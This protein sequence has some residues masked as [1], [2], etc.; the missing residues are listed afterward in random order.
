MQM[1]MQMEQVSSLRGLA[2]DMLALSTRQE[3]IA[4][5]IPPDL[6]DLRSLDLT[7][8]QHRVQKATVGVRDNLAELMDEA[9]NR[10]MKLLQKLDVL[11]E[12]MGRSLRGMEENRAQIAR[13]HARESLAAS[14]RLVI[15]L[16]T[17]AQMAGGSGGGSGSPMPSMAEQLKQLAKEQAGLNGATE[18]LRRMLA[19][20][21]MSQEMRSQMKRLGEEQAGLAG[22]MGELAE[23]ERQRQRPEGE[24]VLGDL[25]EL[26][27]N[28]ETIGQELDDGLVSEETLARQER[29]LSRM[30]DARN[31]VRR[32]DYSTRR[33][34]QTASR[35]FDRQEG[36]DGT[37]DEGLDQP[38]RLRYQPLEKAPLEYRD[39]VRRYFT[40]LDSLRRLDDLPA[41]A[42]PGDRDMP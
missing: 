23:E 26:G 12:E 4:A 18:E 31:S 21:G 5:V 3:E 33:E 35:L 39:L 42:R 40:A 7:R 30:L 36:N 11:I 8:A 1:A 28:M 19:N 20:R 24:R 10:I 9:P 29:I 37:D 32:R 41:P 22:R 34:S 13:R 2:A 17:E 16:L 15:S 38:F 25:G 27:R 14:N 6:R